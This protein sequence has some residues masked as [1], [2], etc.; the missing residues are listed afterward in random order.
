MSRAVAMVM[1]IYAF[2]S[3]ACLRAQVP[4]WFPKAPA[5][6]AATGT[7]IRVTTAEAL[8]KA[9]EQADPGA[10]ILVEDGVYRLPR[11]VVLSGRQRVTIRGASGDPG[12]PQPRDGDQR[13]GPHGTAPAVSE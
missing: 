12:G 6:P 1:T 2:L 11:T 7:L 5:L 3:S 13:G 9:A 4:T 8:L 10:T